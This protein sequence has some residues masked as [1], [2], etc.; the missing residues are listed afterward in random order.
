MSAISIPLRVGDVLCRVVGASHGLAGDDLDRAVWPDLV[1]GDLDASLRRLSCNACQ[2]GLRLRIRIGLASSTSSTLDTCC[3]RDGLTARLARS[4]SAS[5]LIAAGMVLVSRITAAPASSANGA[6]TIAAGVVHG[7]GA[8]A[9]GRR[10]ARDVTVGVIDRRRT[11]AV[12]DGTSGHSAH[13]S[14]SSVAARA[15]RS[16]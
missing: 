7:H 5:C 16:T 14:S 12:G 6:D 10:T 15:H 2:F 1:G 3:C 8:T 11:T 9:A 13:A 4:S